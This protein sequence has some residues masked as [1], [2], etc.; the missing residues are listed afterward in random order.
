MPHD[1]EKLPIRCAADIEPES[2]QQYITVTETQITIDV[3]GV[4]NPY[5]IHLDRIKTASDL[6]GWTV[7][8]SE[9]TW[10]TPRILRGFIHAACKA[11]NI[12]I[13]YG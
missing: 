6:L 8:L 2:D 5:I 10:C 4:G 3:V 9:K 7:H 1:H 12:K 11:N 13:T